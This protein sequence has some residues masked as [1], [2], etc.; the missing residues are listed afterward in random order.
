MSD[1][2]NI[3]NVESGLSEQELLR[4]EKLIALQAEGKDPFDVYKVERTHT[5]G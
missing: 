4:R 5:S 3:N 1:E 2:T